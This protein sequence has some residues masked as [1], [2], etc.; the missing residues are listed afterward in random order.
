ME[1]GR[2]LIALYPAKPITVAQQA[3]QRR[4]HREHW[5][6]GGKRYIRK[7]MLWH[8]VDAASAAH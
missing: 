5:K 8:F 3:H 6:D 2:T 1:S 7:M 4:R